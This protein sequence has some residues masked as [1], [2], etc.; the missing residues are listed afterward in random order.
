MDKHLTP[1][2]IK[3]TFSTRVSLSRHIITATSFTIKC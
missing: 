3:M 1:K 2:K